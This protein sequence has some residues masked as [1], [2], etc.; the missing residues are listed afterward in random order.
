MS[1]RE[2]H[3]GWTL[4]LAEGEAPDAVRS[5]LAAGVSAQVPGVV[6]TDLLTAGLIDDPYVD[7]NEAAQQWIG[8]A[9][10][11]Y[12]LVFE[13]AADGAGR[14]D[15]VADGLDTVATVTLNGEQVQTVGYDGE[16]MGGITNTIMTFPGRDLVVVVTSNYPYADTPGLALKIAEAFAVATSSRGTR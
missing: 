9:D 8:H 13:H 4:R 1:F 6:H 11:T 3:T 10:W 15:L 2:L 12:T 5:A 16:M 7:D 14:H